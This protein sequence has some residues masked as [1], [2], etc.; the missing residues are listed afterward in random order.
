MTHAE[1]VET[2]QED[3]TDAL[4]F[5]NLVVE[6]N[7]GRDLTELEAR[8]DVQEALGTILDWLDEVQDFVEETLPQPRMEA[9]IEA[10]QQTL[11]RATTDV[12]DRQF[13]ATPHQ[14]RQLRLRLEW[15]MDWLLLPLQLIAVLLSNNPP[16]RKTWMSRLDPT[17]CRYCRALHGITIGVNDSFEPYARAAGWA[18]VY[19]SLLTPPLH[20]RCRCQIVLS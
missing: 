18:R 20:P 16:T 2:L 11:D 10:V 4:A 19:G 13:W 6:N 8:P 3:V 1:L 15:L 12:V 5:L 7:P 17:T 14:T 9:D